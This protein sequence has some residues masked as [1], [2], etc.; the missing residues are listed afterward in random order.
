MGQ[1]DGEDV[2]V[3]VGAVV[4]LVDVA[5]G[6]VADSD[7]DSKV[8]LFQA[9]VLELPLQQEPFW[10]VVLQ[11]EKLLHGVTMAMSPG[12]AILLY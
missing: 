7:F 9:T 12:A 6:D 4:A 2:R 1:D 11:H 8:A 3:I 10:P 5:V